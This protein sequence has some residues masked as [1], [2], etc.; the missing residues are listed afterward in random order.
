MIGIR[1]LTRAH[2]KLSQLSFWLGSLSLAA[3]TA[4]FCLEVTARYFFNAPLI[5]AVDTV[6]LLLLCSVFFVIP[7]LTREGGHVAITIFPD[8]L[9]ARFR[10]AIH[11][12][13]Y[14]VSAVACFLAGYILVK[15]TGRVFE[16]GL[17]TLAT[18]P[19]PRGPFAAL[20]S[21]GVI[22]SGLYFL[23]WAFDKEL[24]VQV[25]AEAEAE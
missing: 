1:I 15:D 2:D 22:S 13:V 23:R 9:P 4:I 11:R 24:A 6:S 7:W 3:I 19:M 21:Y 20:V 14:I 18:I 10:P 12:G 5:W 8:M 25:K 16:R 17:M